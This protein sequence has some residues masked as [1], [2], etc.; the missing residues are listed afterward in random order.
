MNGTRYAI[1]R[2]AFLVLITGSV[3]AQETDWPRTVAVEQGTVTLYEPQVDQ[4]DEGFLR[5]R[6]ALAWR[7]EAGADPV[8]GVGWFEADVVTNRFAGTVHPLELRVTQTR[9][10][11]DAPD[12]QPALA[13]VLDGP[14][15]ATGFTFS[16]AGLEASLAGTQAE[17][18]AA[19]RLNTAPPKIIYR[20]HPALLVVLDGPP[21]LR[22][23]ENSPLEAVINTPYP[24]IHDGRYYWLNVADGVWYRSRQ[25]TGPY[26]WVG[27]ASPDVAAVV[28]VDADAAEAPAAPDQKIS[29]QNAP[30][31]IVST[32]PAELIV[33]EGPAAFVPLVDDLLVLQNSDDDVFMHVSGQQYYIVLSGRWYSSRSLNGPWTFR[34]ADRLPP[35]FA[36]IPLES[37]QAGSRVYVAGTEEAGEAVLDAQLPQTAVVARGRAAIEVEYDGNPEFARVD[38]TGMLYARNTGSTVIRADGLYY[39]VE[40]G[41]W[42]LANGPYGPWEVAVARPD[43]VRVIQPSSPVYPVKY[44]YVYDYTPEVVY[45]GYT[46]GYLGSYVYYQTVFYGSGWTYRPW[47]S[48]RYYYPRHSTWG[49]H[50]SYN[51]WSGWGFGLGWYWGPFSVNYYSGGYWHHH[52]H[53]YHPHYG[54]WGPRGYRPSHGHYA[55]RRPGYGGHRPVPYQRHSNLYRDSRQP[56]RVVRTHDREP[57]TRDFYR[58]DVRASRQDAAP[59]RPIRDKSADRRFAKDRF[60]APAKP[61]SRADL[62]A[63]AASRKLTYKAPDRKQPAKARP[64]RGSEM[65]R[66]G[67]AA[68]PNPSR[69]LKHETLAD[70]GKLKAKNDRARVT[71]PSAKRSVTAPGVT[72]K[73]QPARRVG[74]PAEGLDKRRSSAAA[75]SEPPRA[76]SPRGARPEPAAEPSRSVKSS[77]QRTQPVAKPTPVT[78]ARAPALSRSPSP[79]AAPPKAPAQRAAPAPRPDAGRASGKRNA[80]S[81]RPGRPD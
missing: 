63:K 47:V 36:D 27:A 78:P 22:E 70:L 13:A 18:E 16:L 54:Y 48:P 65:A 33:T 35:A 23:I 39:L 7:P 37:E 32:V 67:G 61:V 68:A 14:D 15:A 3:Q 66:S 21:V 12:L 17:Q 75:P 52:H 73:D 38:G 57:G 5:F 74:A 79:A 42:Y 31:I 55:H 46:P 45:V 8:F 4:L 19:Q 69:A 44:V 49:F 53:W 10:P 81:E 2:M 24:L 80:R 6:A 60:A 62:S 51:P 71:T 20:D 25:A 40:D 77:R 50:V 28:R 58:P 64:D 11:A 72:R 30:E 43:E 76:A 56:A 59:D 1:I 9:F 29:A 34:D 41:V 26:A